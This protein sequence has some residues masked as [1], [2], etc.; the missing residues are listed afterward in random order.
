MSLSSKLPTLG[1]LGRGYDLLDKHSYLKQA[2]EKIR[3]H[4]PDRLM[5]AAQ[6]MVGL[7][8]AHS[9]DHP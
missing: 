4:T 1:R 6:R 9:P 7:L 8:W 2:E 5:P 3:E